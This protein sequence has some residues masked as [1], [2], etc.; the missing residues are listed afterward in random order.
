M[1]LD[2]AENPNVAFQIFLTYYTQREITKES[3]IVNAMS[4][5]LER[6][7]RRLGY[8]LFEA[9]PRA[10]MDAHLLFDNL[11]CTRRHEFPSYSWSGWK[12]KINWL[13]NDFNWS[14]EPRPHEVNMSANTWLNTKT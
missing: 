3:D 9:L 5:I 11:Y 10:T 14:A 12:G 2:D 4:G 7:S 8:R 13:Q 6:L 1:A